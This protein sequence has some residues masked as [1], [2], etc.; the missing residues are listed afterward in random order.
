[1]PA[2]YISNSVIRRLPRYYRF[3]GDLQKE[4]ITKISS[5][6]LSVR[7]RLTASQIRQDLNCFGGF[8][9]QGYGY[10]VAELRDK[11]GA[12]I[13][14]EK[15]FKTVLIGAGNLGR[16]IATHF[17]FE[18]NGC[19]LAGIFDS[20][21]ELGDTKIAGLLV[22][23]MAELTDFCKENKPEVAVLCIPKESAGAVCETLVRCG[24]K[25]FWNFSHYDIN[26]HFDDII[27]ENV[28]LGDS[29]LTLAYNVNNQKPTV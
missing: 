27:V 12:I 26:L 6:E 23:S 8:G 1:M 17:D 13:G 7:M 29:L 18:K 19:E 5:A 3:L 20:N 15:K 2:K 24:V 16:S 25:A 21:E 11:I 14:V 10:N 28:H 9:Q 22:R 4:G